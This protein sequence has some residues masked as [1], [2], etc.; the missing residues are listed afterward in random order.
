MSGINQTTIGKRNKMI[1]RIFSIIFLPTLLLGNFNPDSI[2]K[3]IEQMRESKK[4][5]RRFNWWQGVFDE[6]VN[7]WLTWT[8]SDERKISIAEEVE[9]MRKGKPEPWGILYTY[10]YT[11]KYNEKGEPLFPPIE[12]AKREPIKGVSAPFYLGNSDDV[13]AFPGMNFQI[14]HVD[15]KGNS[16]W[17]NRSY[18]RSMFFGNMFI[19]INGVMHVFSESFGLFKNYTKFKVQNQLP[20]LLE[21]KNLTIYKPAEKGGSVVKPEYKW[22]GKSLKYCNPKGEYTL[23]V[24]LENKI[25]IGSDRLVPWIENTRLYISKIRL[26]DLNLIDSTSFQIMDALHKKISGCKLK[27][28]SNSGSYELGVLVEGY[29]DTLLLYLPCRD[30]LQEIVDLVYLCKITKNGIPIKATEVKEEEVKDFNLSPNKLHLEIA[31]W[32]GEFGHYHDR[33]YIGDPFGGPNGMM[34]YGFDKSG[35]MYYYVWYKSDYYW[36]KK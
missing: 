22:I 24:N 4:G 19:D 17:S 21:E 23:C 33:T 1:K 5:I 30:S 36:K 14:I 9:L 12:L 25:L 28:N 32:G 15:N 8:E 13:Y 10:W 18:S 6:K 27:L 35:N 29:G 7:L 34:I 31:F 26:S 2:I 20:T 16:F 3:R 11:Q